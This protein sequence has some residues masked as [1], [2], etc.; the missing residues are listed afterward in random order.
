MPNRRTSNREKRLKGTDRPD[1]IRDEPDFEVVSG[2]PDPP[3]WID[4]SLSE[5]QRMEARR[6][7]RRVVR[8]LVDNR[9][10]RSVQLAALAHYCKIHALCAIGEPSAALR[11]QLRQYQQ[12]FGMTPASISKA[13]PASGSQEGNPFKDM[14]G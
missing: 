13:N 1:R 5:A 14:T 11:T 12:E 2:E 7:W 3:K 9:V 6:E 10:L 4:E 8:E